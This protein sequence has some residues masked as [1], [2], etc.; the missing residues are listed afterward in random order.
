MRGNMGNRPSN[1]PGTGPS[2]KV[3]KNEEKYI[4]GLANMQKR[5]LPEKMPY[6]VDISTRQT[7]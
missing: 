5:F 2:N 4:I 3:H 7:I 6:A 1:I